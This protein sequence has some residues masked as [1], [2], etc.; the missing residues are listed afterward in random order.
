LALALLSLSLRTFWTDNPSRSVLRVHWDEP[1]VQALRAIGQASAE[2][3]AK[4]QQELAG[5]GGELL[6]GEHLGEGSLGLVWQ[7]RGAR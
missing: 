4:V 7:M 1:P 3:I 6:E 5:L 2:A